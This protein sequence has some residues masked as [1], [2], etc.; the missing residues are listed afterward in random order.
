MGVKARECSGFARVN[1]VTSASLRYPLSVFNKNST[2]KGRGSLPQT[3][4]GISA[5]NCHLKTELRGDVDDVFKMHGRQK[6]G[7]VP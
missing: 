6:G 7:K 3:R 1:K 4:S 2:V 5:I